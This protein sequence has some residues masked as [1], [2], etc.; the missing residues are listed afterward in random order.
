MLCAPAQTACARPGYWLI[1]LCVIAVQP[2]CSCA[3]HAM[4]CC[5]VLQDGT[6]LDELDR[7][8]VE[9]SRLTSRQVLEIFRQ[10]RVLQQYRHKSICCICSL[11]HSCCAH[12]FLQPGH[13]S[14]TRS[15][16][17][18]CYSI[19]GRESKVQTLL[20]PCVLLHAGMCRL[21]PH[22]Q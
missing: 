19:R 2:C 6:L 9:G 13:H 8:A 10:V 12:C 20:A 3:D 15:S 7:L 14:A 1:L 5:A 18:R 4:P 22:A 16:M 21:G 17:A 11:L